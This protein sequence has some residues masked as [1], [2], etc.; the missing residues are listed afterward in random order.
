MTKQ[1]CETCD[2]PKPCECRDY[3]PEG[4]ENQNQCATCGG[5]YRR[6]LKDPHGRC[7][8]IC[9]TVP[10]PDCKPASDDR[11]KD[12]L[13]AVGHG[14]PD[15][16]NKATCPKCPVCSTVLEWSEQEIPDPEWVCVKCDRG[17]SP[18]DVSVGEQIIDGL[19][20]ALKNP[21]DLKK[22]VVDFKAEQNKGGVVRVEDKHLVIDGLRWQFQTN[23]APSQ[24]A[25]AINAAIEAEWKRGVRHGHIYGEHKG[26][27][28]AI[29]AIE[30]SYDKGC[31]D[32]MASA[33]EWSDAADEEARVARR[34]A[35]QDCIN[36]C[37]DDCGEILERMKDDAQKED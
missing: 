8:C 4:S 32:V 2:K 33:G 37:C 16:Q 6:V 21:D 17:F 29:L 13:E 14:K 24:I 18:D 7:R 12:F 9:C 26:R 36:E 34:K 27:R 3:F 23:T 11:D 22:T 28:E 35:I 5:V 10:C 31:E 1:T 15:V 20:D 30:A 25:A 19:N